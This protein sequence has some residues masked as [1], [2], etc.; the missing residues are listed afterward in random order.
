MANV[1]DAIGI[2]GVSVDFLDPSL[3]L[4][5]VQNDLGGG[6][7]ET[8]IYKD[9]AHTTVVGH[10]AT[11][12]TT[13][14][15]AIV[16]DGGSGLGGTITVGALVATTTDIVLDYGRWGVVQTIVANLLTLHAPALSGFTVGAI[17]RAPT[18][19]HVVPMLL[20][21][22]GEFAESSESAA[23]WARGK[24]PGVWNNGR[25]HLVRYGV[26]SFADNGGTLPT[27]NV[28][29]GSVLCDSTGSYVGQDVDDDAISWEAKALDPIN[30]VI[31]YEGTIELSV[32]AG[33]GGDTGLSVWT[34]WVVE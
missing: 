33:D 6:D 10:T 13:G 19:P 9:E 30:C 34:V 2:T 14:A 29:I 28:M 27:V 12:T 32:T 1:Y 31:D 23:L 15:K 20:N 5:V 25:A 3:Q 22:P 21:I 18:V 16:A 26:R 24:I 7:F 17:W 4:F 11:Y 8:K